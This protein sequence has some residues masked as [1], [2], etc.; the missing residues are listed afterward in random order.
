ME[1]VVGREAV[2]LLCSHQKN[3]YVHITD[4]GDLQIDQPDPSP[5]QAWLLTRETFYYVFRYN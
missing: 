5:D 3:S 4:K 1:A 2:V